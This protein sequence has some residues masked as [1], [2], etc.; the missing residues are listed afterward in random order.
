VLS[1][2]AIVAELGR[3]VFGDGY[4]DEFRADYGLIRDKIAETIPG[5]EDYNDRIRR[6]G[7]FALPN[8]PRER[9]FTTPSGRAHF[10]VNPLTVLR[11]PPGHLILQT[12]RSHDQ[13]NTT[14]YGLDDR[15][16]GIRGG[17][18]VVFVNP[19]D[20]AALGLLDGEQ[21]TLLSVHESGE[22]RA[23]GFRIVAYDTARG[24]AAA[25]FPETNILVPLDSVADTSQTPTSKSIIVRLERER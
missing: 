12:V 17:R 20:L 2:V 16:R 14:V 22:R 8:G 18:K 4:W 11:P 15:Y 21:V 10:T 1:E 24:C 25:Y 23:P 3:R 6:P 9:R 7:G 19:D 5:F 13:Y